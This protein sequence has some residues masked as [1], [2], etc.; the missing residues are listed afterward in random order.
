MPDTEAFQNVFGAML[1]KPQIAVEPALRRALAV[2]RN[3][4]AKAAQDALAANY[5]VVAMLVGEEAFSACATSYVEVA[6]PREPRLCVYGSSYASFLDAWTPF[7]TAP[8]LASVA[9]AE[10]LVTEALF[11]AD[12]PVL[13]AKAVAAQLD[14]DAPLRLHPATRIHSFDWPVA[15][16]WLAHQD[17]APAALLDELVWQSEILLVTRPG[18]AVEVRAID[19]ATLAFLS[20]STLGEAAVGASEAGGDVATIFADVLAAGAFCVTAVE[21]SFS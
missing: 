15:S 7:V 18:G 2:H 11:A 19:P 3:T 6:P 5:P 21:G 20:A 13:D 12:A 17:N 1:A 4:A 8:Y 10:R 16:L 9:V 14:A